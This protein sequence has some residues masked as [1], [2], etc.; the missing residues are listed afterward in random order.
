MLRTASMLALQTVP[1]ILLL[2]TGWGWD[3]VS[4]WLIRPPL[5]ALLLLLVV[6][7]AAA[8]VLKLDLHPLR[9][10]TEP[11]GRESKELALLLLSSLG[12]LWF[13]PF[14]A[15]RGIWQLPGRAWPWMGVAMCAAGLAVRLFAL[16]ELGPQVS[17]YVTVQPGHRLVTRGI[18]GR[19]RHPLYLS[20]LLAPAGVALVFGSVLALPIFV[21]AAAF[22]ADRI[23][24]EERLLAGHFGEQCELYRRRTAMLVPGLL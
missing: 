15:R 10:G 4:A 7:C 2:V 16:Q 23:R 14:A 21:L 20:L 22:A 12:L 11:G 8:L 9:H 1:G 6:G 5:A 24:K 17:A 19:I 18:Y 13:L 3:D